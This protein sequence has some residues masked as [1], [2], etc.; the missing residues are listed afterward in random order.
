MLQI[1]AIINRPSPVPPITMELQL[2]IRLVTRITLVC[3]DYDCADYISLIP[4]VIVTMDMFSNPAMQIQRKK[5]IIDKL[6]TLDLHCW[7]YL[8]A[9]CVCVCV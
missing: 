4:G 1:F 9:N 8:H 7:M 3:N 6:F 5:L 2:S